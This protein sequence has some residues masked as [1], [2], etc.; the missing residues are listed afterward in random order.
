MKA[1]PNPITARHKRT[2]RPLC[3]LALIVCLLSG[4]DTL[5]AQDTKVFR[6]TIPAASR[7]QRNKLFLEHADSMMIVEA[8]D[9]IV[10][11]G[12]IDFCR[13]DMHLYC[14]SAHY[15][16]RLN[17]VDAFGNVRME[18][19]SKKLSG[20]ADNLHYENDVLNML[21]NV[22][23][24]Q[25]EGVDRQW[26]ESSQIDYYRSSNT[27]KYT[28]GG[29]LED[30]RNILTSQ[31]GTYNFDTNNA[32]FTQD[33]VLDN[34]RDKYVMNTNRLNYNTKTKIAQLVE[35]TTIISDEKDGK[36]N[37]L[38]TNSGTYNTQD[39]VA[40]LY[41]KNQ[42]QPILIAKDGRTLEG[43]TIHY[44]RKKSEG[45]AQGHVRVVDKKHKA[46]LTGGYGCHNEET[47]L[48]Y[49]TRKALARI[50]NAPNAK[51]GE[52]SD[53]L[54]FH[55]DTLK[56]YVERS[57]TTKRVIEAT[58]GARFYR[59]DVQGLCGWLRMSQCD[60]ILNLYNHPI[61]WSEQRQ[62][63]SDHEINVHL[64]DST[65]IDW[66]KLPM[67]GLLVE[68]LGEIYYNQLTAKKIKAFFEQVI[69]YHDDGT[70]E[71]RTEIRHVDADGNVKIVFFPMENDST[72]NK[73]IR[74]ESTHLSANFK[75]KQEI[76]KIKMWPAVTGTV[77]PL[78]IAKKSQ[79]FLEEFKT[80]QGGIKWYDSM[81][82]RQPSDVMEIS[83]EMRNRISQNFTITPPENG[84]QS[85][86]KNRLQEMEKGGTDDE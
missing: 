53:T 61:V 75:S 18:R 13:D 4:L 33:V 25:G 51:T 7:Y 30:S 77:T 19:P 69:N 79:L 63:S 64:K 60:S 2:Q 1:S 41:K 56:T 5:H 47:H 65:T 10:L 49:A 85:E 39:E 22:H 78:Y 12:N 21:G 86:V 70:D 50:Y 83:D 42:K 66:A 72:Y 36:R 38:E 16:D 57:D 52:R 81:R 23:M 45:Y 68:H 26:L 55:A 40:T 82:P 11:K 67:G 27:G 32:V 59:K 62:I 46:I 84:K 6:P 35:H 71:K 37:Q 80:L 34:K 9:Y 44:E 48:S 8:K 43:D 54:Y 20:R 29:K 31:V 14:D 17:K 24:E 74:S 3:L 58:H 28:T 76:E 15:Y 73:C